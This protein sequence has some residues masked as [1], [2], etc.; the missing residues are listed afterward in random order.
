MI[1]SPI[2]ILNQEDLDNRVIVISQS[3]VFSV[4]AM[5]SHQLS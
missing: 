5:K 4:D 3:V 1:L 2:S